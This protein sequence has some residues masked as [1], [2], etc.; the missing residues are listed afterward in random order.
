MTPRLAQA[1]LPESLT[2]SPPPGT[3]PG[4][5]RRPP[6]RRRPSRRRRGGHCTAATRGV[7]TPT[8]AAAAAAAAAGI[9]SPHRGGD[10]A[11]ADSKLPHCHCGQCD[12]ACTGAGMSSL[13]RRRHKAGPQRRGLKACMTRAAQAVLGPRS[14][15]AG[16]ASGSLIAWPCPAR[17]E[18]P[19]AP[20]HILGGARGTA[21]L[22]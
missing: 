4:P 3:R 22:L 21:L 15:G 7:P 8:A 17:L 10:T 18:S 1:R 2:R 12:T 5:G 13:P 20:P 11:V 14:A 9:K 6:R 19:P 16:V